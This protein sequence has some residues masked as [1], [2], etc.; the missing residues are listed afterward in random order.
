MEV[1]HRDSVSGVTGLRIHGLPA[2]CDDSTGVQDFR[3]TYTVCDSGIACGTSCL[4]MVAIGRNG[5][6]Q[7]TYAVP[8][9]VLPPPAVTP[10]K[11]P[12][13][14]FGA[15]WVQVYPNPIQTYA[16]VKMFLENNDAVLVQ[17]YDLSGNQL[18]MVYSGNLSAEEEKTVEFTPVDLPDGMYIMRIVCASGQQMHRKF[19]ILR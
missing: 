6:V 18:Q 17:I 3:I 4:P 2:T 9:S 1:L 15:G 16:K 7:Y 11:G 8:G 12:E 13:E 10:E 19:T 5:C 14:R